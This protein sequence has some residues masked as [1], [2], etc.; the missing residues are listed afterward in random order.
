MEVKKKY[1][2]AEEAMKKEEYKLSSK[3]WN[4][5]VLDLLAMVQVIGQEARNLVRKTPSI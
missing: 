1:K 3:Y 4:K 2:E 5:E